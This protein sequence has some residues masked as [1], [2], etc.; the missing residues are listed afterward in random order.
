M[1]LVITS[2][3]KCFRKV[4][5]GRGRVEA[6]IATSDGKE[7]SGQW[8][9]LHSDVDVEVEPAV[10]DGLVGESMRVTWETGDRTKSTAVTLGVSQTR[11]GMD[12][13]LFAETVEP[14]NV[15]G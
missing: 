10:E 8:D 11:M 3:L 12:I 9:L 1:P 5:S 15:R 2:T 4:S 13:A 14:G 7:L 6:R